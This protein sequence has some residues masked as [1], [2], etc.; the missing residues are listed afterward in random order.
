MTGRSS[1]RRREKGRTLDPSSVSVSASGRGAAA[2][3]GDISGIVSTGPNAANV[4]MQGVIVMVQPP[5]PPAA[6][7][8]DEDR[9]SHGPVVVGDVPQEPAAFQHRADLVA[10]LGAQGQGVSVVH[11]VTGMR[12]VG[13][14][15]LAAAYARSCIASGWRLVAWVDAV[16]VASLLA[17]LGAVAIGLKM[18]TD[19]AD[20]AGIGMMVRHWLE[21]DGHDCLVVFD[22]AVDV[23]GL[24]PFLPAAGGAQIVVTSTRQAA[25]NLGRGVAVGVL[26]KPKR[27]P[28]WQHGP[29]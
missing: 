12:G 27:W 17:G 18:I 22:N 5:G 1:R 3:G 26:Q 6:P 20:A 28:S 9:R 7:V 16:D 15:Q 23:D 8:S 21:I 29:A 2:V 25:E 11:A 14:T 13:K 10:E 4:Q 19:G 24:R